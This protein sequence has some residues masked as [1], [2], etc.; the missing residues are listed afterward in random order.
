[1]KRA[2][3]FRLER[4]ARARA[5]AEEAARADLAAA[6]DVARRADERV[7]ALART[8]ASGHVTQAALQTAG[9]LDVRGLLSRDRS[10][11]QVERQ[12]QAA[13]A[14]ARE[15][16][17]RA[18][19]QLAV[20]RDRKQDASALET[21]EERHREAHRQALQKAENA[22]LDEA[23]GQRFQNRRRSGL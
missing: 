3:R 9:R 15:A 11:E 13:H 18:E 2:F 14:T 7:D 6:Q 16:A 4:V 22:E 20:W 8:I 1:M 5:L 12:L 10:L 21:L 23:A 19:A 17:E